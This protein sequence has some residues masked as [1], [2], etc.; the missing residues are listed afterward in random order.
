MKIKLLMPIAVLFLALSMNVKA[1]TGR[2]DKLYSMSSIGFALP[3]GETSDY[4]K[5]KFSTALGLNLALG[6]KGL[7]LY[8]KVSL[9]AFQFNQITPDAGFNYT[10]QKGRATTYLLN[11]ALGY[12]KIV[13]KWAYYGF[14]GA[15]GGFILT[16]QASVNAQTLQVTMDN[17]TNS[18]GIF[19]AGGG[20]EYNIGSANL[21]AEVSYMYGFGKIQNRT[22]NTVPISIGI[23]PNLSKLLS[24][25]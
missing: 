13:K 5:P 25:L 8:P 4:L 15:G 16:P 12:R 20:L 23:K 22:F 18:T 11:V 21:F 14:A 9:H 1:Q 6:T 7:F 24:K 19:E 10:L 3:V 2:P 17:K